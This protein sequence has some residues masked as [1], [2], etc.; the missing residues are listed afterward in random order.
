MAQFIVRLGRTDNTATK[1]LFTRSKRLAVDIANALSY[2]LWLR[3]AFRSSE[4]ADLVRVEQDGYWIE[5]KP[6]L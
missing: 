4:C 5:V 6:E 2:V 1:T 3:H